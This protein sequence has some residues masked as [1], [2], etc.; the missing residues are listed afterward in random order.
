MEKR[1]ADA[2]IFQGSQESCK[3]VS[4]ENKKVSDDLQMKSQPSQNSCKKV[5]G[6]NKKVSDDLQMKSKPSQKSRNK[7]SG[8][9]KK[10][11]DDL[12]MKSSHKSCEEVSGDNK[13]MSDDLQMKSSQKSCEEVSGENKKV[14]DDLQMRSKSSQKSCEKVTGEFNKVADDLQMKSKSDLESVD[15]SKSS[16]EAPHDSKFTKN[17]SKSKNSS[18]EVVTSRLVGGPIDQEV[19]ETKSLTD[20]RIMD[21]SSDSTKGDMNGINGSCR[22]VSKDSSSGANKKSFDRSLTVHE[23]KST[24]T[25]SISSK[26]I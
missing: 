6:D 25:K 7:V 13:K 2:N 24:P 4:S 20:N 11:S 26:V 9:N 10:I 22:V 14:F 1:S 17:T 19:K 12:Q 15:V 18:N 3:K 16:K 21:A 5:S 23:R 8:D